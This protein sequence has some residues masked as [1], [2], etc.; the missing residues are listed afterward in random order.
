MRDPALIAIVSSVRESRK[1]PKVWLHLLRGRLEEGDDVEVVHTDGSV[2]SRRFV[3]VGKHARTPES[4]AGVGA[5]GG[6]GPF[7]QAGAPDGSYR[8]GDLV[9]GKDGP[10]VELDPT[11]PLAIEI[12]EARAAG[13]NVAGPHLSD[14]IVA[15]HIQWLT[16][17]AVEHSLGQ[18]T[19]SGGFQS[20]SRALAGYGLAEQSDRAMLL[21]AALE[22]GSEP[23]AAMRGLA[24]LGAG[25]LGIATSF[26]TPTTISG[27]GLALEEGG[28]FA[29]SYNK[30]I[31]ASGVALRDPLLE[32]GRAVA[33]GWCKKC[34]EV[35]PLD[36][37]LKCER[38]GK[39]SEA[40]G[41]VVPADVVALD[42][43]LRATH[44]AEHRHGLFG[45]R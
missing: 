8:V 25:V 20:L 18:V 29:K 5:I 27:L 2:E 14:G 17:M 33:R 12:A 39:R 15:L 3:D 7:K 30:S 11:A 35:M 32:A 23:T 41:I 28:Q 44:A 36:K 22:E 34:D 37:K 31:A 19:M 38:C 45:R 6:T 42:E 40:Y 10:P 4:Y 43:A 24:T 26:A 9:R 1:G 13:R 21:A 16:T